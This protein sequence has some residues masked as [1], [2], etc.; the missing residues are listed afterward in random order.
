MPI[1]GKQE[2]SGS[3]PDVGLALAGHVG[4][5]TGVLEHGLARAEDQR[6]I[7]DEHV[8]GQHLLRPL[9]LA[10]L[11]EAQTLRQPLVDVPT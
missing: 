11:G 2:V 7:H 8:P 1:H 6:L 5:P 10:R 4:G 3:S 9:R